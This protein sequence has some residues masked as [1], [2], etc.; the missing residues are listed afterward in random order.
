MA[1]YELSDQVVNN[2]RALVVKAPI[3]YEN[4]AQAVNE[5][6]IALSKPLP[7]ENTKS[8]P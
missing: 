4:G 5:V 7:E 2:I 8:V 3:T 1:R 6:L